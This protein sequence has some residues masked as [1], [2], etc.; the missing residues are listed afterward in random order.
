MTVWEDH[1][2]D[3]HVVSQG[4]W[5]CPQGHGFQKETTQRCEQ[6]LLCS[7]SIKVFHYR[8]TFLFI[9]SVIQR[10]SYVYY[11]LFLM[12]KLGNQ[13]VKSYSRYKCPVCLCMNMP[14]FCQ[15]CSFK[16]KICEWSYPRSQYLSWNPAN[17][18]PEG[19]LLLKSG[20]V[21]EFLEGGHLS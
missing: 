16:L 8:I 10:E 2:K 18:T 1:W 6:H 15:V 17:P 12:Y 3:M 7:Q 4:S 9:L 21:L 14:T 13:K 19:F 20:I 11:F 5:Y